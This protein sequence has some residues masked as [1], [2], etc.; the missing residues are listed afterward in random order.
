MGNQSSL[1]ARQ[2]AR[3]EASKSIDKKLRQDHKKMKKEVKILLL[4]M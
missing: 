1:L 2:N 4:G 3:V